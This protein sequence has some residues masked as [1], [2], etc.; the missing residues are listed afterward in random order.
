MQENTFIP[1]AT[2]F[3]QPP[4]EFSFWDHSCVVGD[5]NNERYARELYVLIPFTKQIGES[6]DCSFLYKTNNENPNGI[7]G[8]DCGGVILDSTI[9]PT[10]KEYREDVRVE[11]RGGQVTNVE[12]FSLKTG[13]PLNDV[14]LNLI[15][16]H[17]KGLIL[18]I[19]SMNA[20]AYMTLKDV[21]TL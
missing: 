1:V 20:G 2:N 4:T 14:R 17:L 15:P 21:Q 16:R 12:E 6:V 19:K 3:E 8:V 5:R 13:I 10:W 9:N 18:R 11:L 7:L